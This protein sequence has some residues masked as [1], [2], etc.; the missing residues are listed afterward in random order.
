MKK[1]FNWLIFYCV[2]A[3]TSLVLSILNFIHIIYLKWWI[4]LLPVWGP[5]AIVVGLLILLFMA[6]YTITGYDNLKI[7]K[8]NKKQNK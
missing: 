2:M 5:I 3:T 6:I 8:E 1:I 7:I 4:V